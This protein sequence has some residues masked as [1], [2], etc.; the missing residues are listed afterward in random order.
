[1]V[2]HNFLWPFC[3]KKSFFET[4]KP[5]FACYVMLFNH[6]HS[7]KVP[8]GISLQHK[9]NLN[10]RHDL[11][12]VWSNMNPQVCRFRFRINKSAW[13]LLLHH[14]SRIKKKVPLHVIVNKPFKSFVSDIQTA[15]FSKTF[16]CRVAC[17]LFVFFKTALTW[18]HCWFL[19]YM[20]SPLAIVKVGRALG[21]ERVEKV[22]FVWPQSTHDVGELNFLIILLTIEGADYH[23]EHLSFQAHLWTMSFGT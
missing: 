8:V 16:Q 23:A 18:T 14:P 22:T 20:R 12:P 10:H 4:F 17:H 13:L 2:S 1:M 3:K 21:L 19:F 7:I 5:R 6:F 15:M 11:F 9:Q